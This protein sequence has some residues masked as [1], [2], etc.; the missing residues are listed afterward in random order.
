MIFPTLGVILLARSPDL[1]VRTSNIDQGF[2]VLSQYGLN[3]VMGSDTLFLAKKGA[4]GQEKLLKIPA[5]RF[6]RHLPDKIFVVED[7]VVILASDGAGRYFHYFVRQGRRGYS[8]VN[9]PTGST[10]SY[11]G[12]SNVVKL[13]G[14]LLGCVWVSPDFSSVLSGNYL[15][16]FSPSQLKFGRLPGK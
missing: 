7:R 10:D 9:W 2:Y 3:E 13:G 8:L 16:V 5:L 11:S 15:Y 1:P 14:N 12:S 4:A 6:D